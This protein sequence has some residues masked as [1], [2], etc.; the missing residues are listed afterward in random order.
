LGNGMV[1]IAGGDST[2]TGLRNDAVLYNPA[3]NTFSTA[4]NTMALPREFATATLLPNGKVLIAGGFSTLV[5]TSST[6]IFDPTTNQFT[7]GPTMNNARQHAVAALLSN[8]TVLIAG[9][10][11]GSNPSATAT[12]EIYDPVSNTFAATPPTM[13]NARTSLMAATLPSSDVLI[14]GGDDNGSSFNTAEIYHLGTNNFSIVSS[15]MNGAREQ[16]TATLL[17]N[18]SVLISG[19]FLVVSNLAMA[20][21]TTELYSTASGTFQAS[22]GTVNMNNARANMTATLLPNGFVLIAGG[23]TTPGGSGLSTTEYYSSVDNT[24]AATQPSMTAGR[25]LATATLM[26]NGQVIIAGGLANG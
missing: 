4:L 15:T 12:S 5:V 9:G 13:N 22:S 21:K 8:G 1:L 17:P 3:N 24:F 25:A 6:S 11:I 2:S 14:A 16:G 19:G 23:D 10:D 18:G 7:T 20:E 26:Q